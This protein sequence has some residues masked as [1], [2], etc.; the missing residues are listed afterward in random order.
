[1]VGVPCRV[2]NT[3]LQISGSDAVNIGPAEGCNGSERERKKSSEALE[4]SIPMS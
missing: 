3:R 1:M 2:F 4:R